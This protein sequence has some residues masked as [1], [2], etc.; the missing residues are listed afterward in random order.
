MSTTLII[1]ELLIIGCQVLVWVALLLNKFHLVHETLV[2]MKPLWSHG[3]SSRARQAESALGVDFP[4]MARHSPCYTF[5]YPNIFYRVLR[6]VMQ[7]EMEHPT[8]ARG[9]PI[10][11]AA[12]PRPR[13]SG[14]GGGSQNA[15]LH[16]ENSVENVQRPVVVCHDDDSGLLFVCN[17]AE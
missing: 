6:G 5:S 16:F 4:L 17:H 7:N 12:Q 11:S 15:V 10:R 2:A 9:S 3:P 8:V 1:V 14:S 13:I